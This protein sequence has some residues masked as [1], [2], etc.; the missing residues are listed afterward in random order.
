[1]ETRWKAVNMQPPNPKPRQKPPLLK[2]IV[3]YKESQRSVEQIFSRITKDIC[4]FY[5]KWK[6][7]IE[8]LCIFYYRGIVSSSYRGIRQG[9][10]IMIQCSVWL[11]EEKTHKKHGISFCYIWTEV[12]SKVKQNKRPRHRGTNQS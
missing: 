12:Y 11:Q 8:R 2:M 5:R 9:S 6:L 3:T 4:L 7:K 1:M 10:L